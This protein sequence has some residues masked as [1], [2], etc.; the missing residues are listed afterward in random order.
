MMRLPLY[1]WARGGKIAEF[2]GGATVIIDLIGPERL[3]AW[4]TVRQ[5]RS[6]HRSAQ[7]SNF[8][9]LLLVIGTISLVSPGLAIPLSED[10]YF[11]LYMI[12]LVLLGHALQRVLSRPLRKMV[13]WLYRKVIETLEGDRP[14]YAWRVV[15]FMVLAIGFHFDILGS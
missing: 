9:I 11:Y 12:S 15:G 10:L 5:A 13:G 14:A 1:W 7:I 2:I 8:L 4:S 6:H 3:R